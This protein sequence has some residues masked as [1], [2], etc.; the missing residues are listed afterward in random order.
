MGVPACG[1]ADKEACRWPLGSR[2][3]KK[4]MEAQWGGSWA[5]NH[6][7]TSGYNELVM[8]RRGRSALRL[9]DHHAFPYYA[10]A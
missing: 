7:G 10:Q 3:L 5:A 6:P 8:S 1:I 9:P 4:A 2:T